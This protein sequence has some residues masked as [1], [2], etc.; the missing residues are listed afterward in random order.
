M[1]E[2]FYVEA[3]ALLAD[4]G[5]RCEEAPNHIARLRF[6]DYRGDSKWEVQLNGNNT[7]E[8]SLGRADEMGVTIPPFG[9]AVWWNDWLAGLVN[10]RQGTLAAH[11]TGANAETFLRSLK[12]HLVKQKGDQT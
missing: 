5:A 3:I 8:H 7:P 1:T 10:M 4:A 9:F 2:T 11:P 6:R 12:E